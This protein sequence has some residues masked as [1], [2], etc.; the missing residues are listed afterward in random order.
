MVAI[1][2]SKNYDQFEMTHFN[3]DVKNTKKLEQS[4]KKYGWKDGFP[5][6]VVPNGGKVLKIKAGHNRF[7]AAKKLNIPVKYVLDID[8]DFSIFEEQL[9]T[10]SWNLS[11]YLVGHI[12]TG[13]VAY[14]VLKEFHKSSGIA[15]S[16]CVALLAGFTGRSSKAEDDFKAGSY[17]IK[18]IDHAS[19]VK[20]MVQFCSDLNFAQA[21]NSKFVTAMSRILQ[22]EGIDIHRLKKK[23][24]SRKA[25][26][27]PQFNIKAYQD[28]IEYIYNYHTRNQD[29][30]NLSFL[31]D[32]LG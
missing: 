8:D 1:R 20:Q 13:N 31:A 26:L 32:N 16:L 27:K 23:L 22:V 5:M 12:R 6:T 29:K 3:R 21:T 25:C 30:L 17:K 10:K 7:T 18:S 15:L 4:M 24:T 28:L 9:T 19:R 14:M 2:E 11:D